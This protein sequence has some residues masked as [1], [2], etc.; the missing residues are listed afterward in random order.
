MCGILGYLKIKNNST[1][2]IDF[3]AALNTM[4]HRGPDNSAI[5]ETNEIFLGHRR[6]SIIDLSGGNQPMTSSD[7]RW[8]IIYNGELYNYREIKE[9]LLKKGYSFITSS[10]T[11]VLLNSYITWGVSCLHKF[12][13]MFAFS[14]WDNVKKELFIARDRLGIKPLYYIATSSIFA[15]SS[16]IKALV[17][18]PDIKPTIDLQSL[19]NYLS[20]RYVPGP[21]SI[22]QGIKKLEPGHYLKISK[23][24]FHKVKYW[25]FPYTDNSFSNIKIEE[26][27]STLFKESVRRRLIADVPVGIFLSGGLDSTAVMAACHELDVYKM[28]SFTVAFDTGGKYDES[29]YAKIA[30]TKY[31][32]QYNEIIIGKTEFLSFL[33]KVTYFTDE[34]LADLASIPLYFVAKLAA[35]Q[36]K[37][38]LSGEGSDEILGGYYFDTFLQQLEYFQKFAKIP[39]SQLIQTLLNVI[40]LHRAHH[41]ARYVKRYNTNY[42][43]ENMIDMTSNLYFSDLEKIS[44]LPE[45]KNLKSSRQLITKQLY[46]QRR[47]DHPFDQLLYVISKDWLVEDLLMKADKMTMANS[48]ELRVPFL[49]HTLVEFASQLP[50]HRKLLKNKN[51]KYSSK[52]LLRSYGQ[53]RIPSEIINRKKQ[54]FPVPVYEWLMNDYA[55]LAHDILFDSQGIIKQMMN[56]NKVKK[57]FK[58]RN[59]KYA[60]HKLWCLIILSLWFKSF[61]TSISL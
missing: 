33:D 25:D 20:Y 51:G 55:G 35:E 28:S 56:R 46:K 61:K 10:D 43:D 4:S 19:S 9:E 58:N 29:Q 52:S 41:L 37:V 12:N 18:L 21:G 24:A 60:Q 15:L 23:K 17:K 54:G 11:E 26:T 50:I 59:S 38:V 34:P 1:S 16:E 3:K 27:F 45:I 53:N 31:N 22:F 44:L 8:T 40:P 6:L 30:S 7:K 5:Y 57:I 48:L 49:D 32:C 2:I 14:I 39:G 42:L 36:V 13:G 47:Q